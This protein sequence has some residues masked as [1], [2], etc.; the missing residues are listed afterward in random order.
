MDF[1]V[2][3]DNFTC[4]VGPNGSGK[5][6]IM[7]AISFV[8]GVQSRHLRSSQ[9]KDL[10]YRKDAQAPAARKAVVSLSYVA[11]KD[12]IEGADEGDSVLF[13]R[14][15]TSAGASTYRINGKEISF[16]SF[17][18]Q[19]RKIGVLVKVRNFLVFQGDVEAVANKSPVEL[20]RMIEQI[21]GSEQYREEYEELSR[22]KEEAEENALYTLQ[23]KKMFT[24]QRKEVKD[25][26][27]EAESF[28]EK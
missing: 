24:S 15:V 4:I 8:L 12:E 5:S 27:D 1:A 6:N 21:S 18:E 22:K 7:D 23:K 26:R 9:L 14:S 19:L 20:M 25:Q 17:E 13:S 28:L 11:D 3:A 16:E 2:N 10:I